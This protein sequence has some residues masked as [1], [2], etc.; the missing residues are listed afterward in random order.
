LREDAATQ[1]TQQ[2][3]QKLLTDVTESLMENTKF[4][5]PADFLKRWI[6]ASGEKEMTIEEVTAEY[7]RSEKGLRY[8]LIE[9]YLVKNNEDLQLKF[10]DLQEYSRTLIRQQMLQYGHTDATD[11]EVDSVVARIMSNQEEVKRMSEQLQNEKM[12]KFFKENVKLKKKE[13]TYDEFI[14]EAYGA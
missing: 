6:A 11:E 14:K 10:E 4:D 2:T 1:F 5:L 13:V 3:D 12:L 9:S 7:D 8:Q